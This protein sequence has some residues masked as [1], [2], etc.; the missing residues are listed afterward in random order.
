MDRNNRITR[1]KEYIASCLYSYLSNNLHEPVDIL[2]AWSDTGGG[3][4][5]NFII[6]SFWLRVL[7]KFDINSVIHRF[8]IS[9]HSFLP[10]DRDFADV[11][12]AKKKKDSI[13]TVDQ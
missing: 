11:E 3:E 9:G 12:E 4:N 8:P 10:N 5:R 2:I 1:I 13:Y 7:V 6:A